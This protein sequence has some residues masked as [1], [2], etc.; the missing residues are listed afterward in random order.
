M[1][2]HIFRPLMTMTANKTSVENIIRRKITDTLKPTTLEISNDSHKHAH[3]KPMRGSSSAETHFRLVITSSEFAGK[4]LV[5]RHRLV[6]KI[7]EDDMAR[8]NGIHAL[9][10]RTLSPEEEEGKSLERMIEP[11]TK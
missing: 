9:Q 10:L 4:T 3:H 1:A 7:L 8:E 6:N 2:L 5:Q 11:Q